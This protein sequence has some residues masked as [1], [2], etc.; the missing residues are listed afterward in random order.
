MTFRQKFKRIPQNIYCLLRPQH[1]TRS[2][3]NNFFYQTHSHFYDEI[4][5]NF[6]IYR[7]YLQQNTNHARVKMTFPHFYG[8]ILANSARRRAYTQQNTKH[9]HVEMTVH[10]IWVD[11]AKLGLFRLQ[12]TRARGNGF[13]AFLW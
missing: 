7:A 4:L 5:V 10:T 3:E 11:P 13:S 6:S 8:E 2:H 9:T 12:Q 1:Q